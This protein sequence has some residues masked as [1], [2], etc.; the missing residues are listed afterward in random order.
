METKNTLDQILTGEGCASENKLVKYATY[1]TS[2]LI[3]GGVGYAIYKGLKNSKEIKN[4]QA[5]LTEIKGA[6]L[7]APETETISI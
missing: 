2:A 1:A 5:Q 6:Q 4:L 7:T 3:I